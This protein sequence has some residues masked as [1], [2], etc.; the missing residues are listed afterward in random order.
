MLV[1]DHEIVRHG[2]RAVLEREDDFE[3]VGETGNGA[4]AVE[5][6]ETLKPDILITD[7]MIPGLSGLEVIRQVGQRSAETRIIV[8]SMHANEAYVVQAL[9]YGAMGYIL[10]E[11]SVGDVVKA[12][13]EV[14]RGHRYLSTPLSDRII[15]AYVSKLQETVSDAYETLTNR[16][17][18]ILHLTAEGRSN[19]EISRYYSISPRTVEVHRS[20][21]MH[22][23][24]LHS[25]TELI[26]FALRRGILPGE[27]EI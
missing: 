24:G 26:R 12:V 19:T 10:K 13:Y 4:E 7:L 14:L 27:A 21:L 25:Q 18:E 1:E 11:S 6:C 15:E 22:K 8:L 17:R 2:L 23:L 9:N 3:I 5:L 16:E 20:N